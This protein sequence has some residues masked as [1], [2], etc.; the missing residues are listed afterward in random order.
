MRPKGSEFVCVYIYVLMG[1]MFGLYFIPL[2]ST[3][4][5]QPSQI[6]RYW[7]SRHLTWKLQRKSSFKLSPSS[8]FDWRLL[9]HCLKLLWNHRL[10][11]AFVFTLG[12]TQECVLITVGFTPTVFLLLGKRV[13]CDCGARTCHVWSDAKSLTAGP[14]ALSGSAFP[15]HDWG[16]RAPLLSRPSVMSQY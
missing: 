12:F 2:H 11:R 5:C 10:H 7:I 8:S 6:Q 4:N 16:F 14:P 9:L 15:Q 13:R 1:W 3:K